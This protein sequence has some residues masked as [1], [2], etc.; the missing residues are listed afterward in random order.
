[1]PKSKPR[2]RS[3]TSQ[4]GRL[5]RTYKTSREARR[6]EAPTFFERRAAAD[7]SVDH[8]SHS[9]AWTGPCPECPPQD[10]PASVASL[11]MSDAPHS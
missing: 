3:V 2:A 6:A 1:M 7:P 4:G 9:T 11:L 5:V 8:S 10:G